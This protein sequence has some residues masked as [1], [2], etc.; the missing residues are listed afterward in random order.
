MWRCLKC[1]EEHED[2][3]AACWNCGTS[4]DAVED[5]AFPRADKSIA[6]ATQSLILCNPQ[7]ICSWNYSLVGD[8]HH[9]TLEFNWASEQGHITADDVPFEVRKH[10]LFSGYW[11]LDCKGKT[12]ASAQKSSAFRRTFAI[13]SPIGSL[14]L[15]AESP[16][17]R[18]FRV[19]RS[20]EL[21]ATVSPVHAF[22]RRAS[23]ATLGKM[24]S[25]ATVSFS[26]WLV[27]LTWRRAASGAGASSG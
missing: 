10:G 12:V 17:A 24:F 19:E 18:S 16:F 13:E 20:G 7:G 21:L 9:A 3:F 14:V 15:R 11:T 5:A 8:G 6:G 25:F 22:T 23:I 2:S 27:A 26:F 4:K 1:G